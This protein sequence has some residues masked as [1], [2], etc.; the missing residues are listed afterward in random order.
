MAGNSGG[1][2][3]EQVGAIPGL[4]ELADGGDDD[5]IVYALGVDPDG[6]RACGGVGG[7]G[8]G[9]GGGVWAASDG[10]GAGLAGEA[11]G[12]RDDGAGAASLCERFN[13][14]EGGGRSG[15][16]RLSPSRQQ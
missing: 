13:F 10:R 14:L 9:E 12:G 5:I 4:L 6:G 11:A 8:G 2:L 1:E 16:R 7:G 15:E 3:L